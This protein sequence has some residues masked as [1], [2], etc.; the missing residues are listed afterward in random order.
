MTDDEI[1]G[2]LI[3]ANELDGRHS[4]NEAKIYAWREV[5]DAE[6][7]GM[8]MAF[9]KEQIT[10]HYGKMDTM[11]APAT[12]TNAWRAQRRI[13]A[14]ARAARAGAEAER[15]CGKAGCQCAHTDPC[16]KGWIDTDYQTSPCRM[17]RYDLS[18]ILYN[19][20]EPGARSSHDHATIRNRTYAEVRDV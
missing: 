18:E 7:P 10:K 16:Y 4:P 11:L 9:A 8:T 19:I 14:E 13:E 5:L 6:A 17:C 3:Y 2:L 20:P 15:H 1:L 12:L